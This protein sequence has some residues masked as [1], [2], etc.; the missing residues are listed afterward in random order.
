MKGYRYRQW[1]DDVWMGWQ[2]II[3]SFILKI[4]IKSTLYTQVGKTG[5]KMDMVTFH[6]NQ[7]PYS[8]VELA[9]LLSTTHE[10]GSEAAKDTASKELTVH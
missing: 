1:K 2:G 5:E 10:L 9:H 8:P 7:V 4:S 6:L 3:H